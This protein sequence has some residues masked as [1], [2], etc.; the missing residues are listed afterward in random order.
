[1]QKIVKRW[2]SLMLSVLLAVSVCNWNASAQ[3]IYDYPN[4]YDNTGTESVDVVEIAKTQVGYHE[5]AFCSKY[6]IFRGN[7]L[8]AWCNFFVHWVLNE[9]GIGKS[10]F[11]YTNAEGYMSR[12]DNY[13]KKYGIVYH[14]RDGYTPIPGDIFLTSGHM[15]IV[16]DSQHIISGNDGNAVKIKTIAELEK[17]FG[18]ITYYLTPNYQKHEVKID[19]AITRIINQDTDPREVPYEVGKVMAR[20]KRNDKVTLVA[21]FVNIYGNTWYKADKGYWIYG[22]RLSEEKVS[23]ISFAA[24][25]SSN[26]IMKKINEI[27]TVPAPIMETVHGKTVIPGP[28]P[29]LDGYTFLG[30][31][32]KP[33]AETPEYLIGQEI[34]VP[35]ND[36]NLYCV[37]KLER[38][39]MKLS[40]NKVSLDLTDNIDASATVK[41]TVEGYL[42]VSKK[43]IEVYSDNTNVVTVSATNNVFTNKLLKDTLTANINISAKT[44][45]N[46]NIIVTVKDLAGTPMVRQTII[47]NVDESYKVNF[48]DGDTKAT[49]T[50]TK[51][52]NKNLTLTDFIPEKDEHIR[53]LGWST[54][55]NSSVVSFGPGDIYKDN[56]SIDFYAVWVTDPFIEPDFK[57]G[58]LTITGKGNMPSY[59]TGKTKWAQYKDITK[60]I[61]IKSEANKEITSIG[62]NAFAGFKNVT[63]IEIPNTVQYIGS[64][65]FND[66]A[67]SAVRIPASIMK[68]GNRAFGNCKNLVYVQFETASAKA[69]GIKG[70]RALSDVEIG[71]FAFENCVNLA[72][73][74]LPASVTELGTG[75]FTGCSTLTEVD[76]PDNLTSVEDS[77]FFGCSSLTDVEIPDT[78]TQIGD[79]AFNGCTALPEIEL[80]E[81]LD[82][83]GDQAFSGCAAIEEVVIPD[84]IEDYGA[85]IFANC[86]ALTTVELPDDIEHIPDAMFSG[87]TAMEAIEIPDSVE[88]IGSSA[89]RNCSALDDVEI[90]ENVTLISSDAF[91][92]CSAMEN[93]VIP[94]SVT[95]IGDFAFSESSLKTVELNEGLTTIGTG[96]FAF[97]EE[98]EGIAVPASVTLID[99]GAFMGCSA[100]EEVELL[101]SP[102][103]IGD[104]AFYGCSSL[105]NL[106]L[107]ESIVSLG[108]NAFEGCAASFTVAC[109]STSSVYDQ[110]LDTCD[111]V[112]SIYPVSGVSLNKST[113]AAFAGDTVQLQAIVAPAN[114]TDQSVV[115]TTN[116]P[117]I[118]TVD[119][120]GLVSTTKG[121]TVVITATTNDNKLVAECEITV[122][123]P[124]TG[125]DLSYHETTAYVGDSFNMGYSFEPTNPTSIGVSW[126]TTDPDVATVSESGEVTIVGVGSATITATTADGGYT[127]SCVVNTEEYIDVEGVVLEQ[128]ELTLRVGDTEKI[129]ASVLPLNATD[130]YISYVVPEGAEEYIEMDEGGN[131]TALKVGTVAI[132]V[133]AGGVEEKT[134]TVT[135]LEEAYQVTWVVDGVETKVVYAPG[136]PIQKPADPQKDGFD[137]KGWTPEIPDVMPKHDLTFTAVFEAVNPRTPGDVDESGTVTLRDA[138]LISRYL[139]GGWDVTINTDNADVD[140]S[141][142]VTLRDAALISRYLAGG[143]NVEL[144]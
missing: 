86:S 132:T 96:A 30:Y 98:L 117:E 103:E 108:E 79:S 83:V 135:I 6:G 114:A 2:T 60:K 73:V 61:V 27:I 40:S 119:E 54:S 75:A 102:M 59:P 15:G 126:T 128:T 69:R 7:A 136:A 5:V 62:S 134:C 81:N 4:T 58:V 66:T 36:L 65:A 70:T 50:Q 25:K 97:C 74:D 26:R 72:S 139:A 53:F 90:S 144:I 9:A 35:L 125:I 111:H 112:D 1:M 12:R 82:T 88:V 19:P 41:A 121:G 71:A 28:A 141:N 124:V 10:R 22:E 42:D 77:V 130:P 99:D 140:G 142:T 104:D 43:E 131:I 24:Q 21:K 80:P 106:Q 23:K 123:V 44:P 49:G 13:S 76:L 113:A 37:W 46:A 55:K 67:L 68:I 78:V 92:G 105:T 94:S 109:F 34:D 133:T 118:A 3:G 39:T 18:K 122:T 93:I 84:G 8:G 85:G 31:S 91:N 16:I 57:D 129:N 52:F 101:E 11:P 107:P 51:Y 127:S 89:F 47:V 95:E 14:K 110:V 120:N 87:C 116:H 20:L 137:F 48:Y 38:N 63:E 29:K 33:N 100:M 45:G 32:T 115:W 143:W 64:K 17:Y 56:S 138:A